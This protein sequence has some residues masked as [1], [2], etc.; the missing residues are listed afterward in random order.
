MRPEVVDRIK[1]MVE[2]GGT[3]ASIARELHVNEGTVRWKLRQLEIEVKRPPLSQ[4]RYARVER[5]R[6]AAK[7]FGISLIHRL[8]GRWHG[9]G[10]LRSWGTLDQM[11]DELID[12]SVPD[13]KMVRQMA[14]VKMEQ[15]LQERRAV[16]REALPAPGE[17]AA[18]APV[19]TSPAPMPSPLVQPAVLVAVLRQPMLLGTVS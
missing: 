9:F 6:T 7:R 3:G 5:C 16:Q 14:A 2:A 10:S 19:P 18:G 17:A 8:E 13:L 4:T 1:Q 15:T 12:G 11:E